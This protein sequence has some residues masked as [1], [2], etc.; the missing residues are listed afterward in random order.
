MTETD[1]QRQLHRTR[2]PY[3]F[4]VARTSILLFTVG[5]FEGR[6]NQD[7]FQFLPPYYIYAYDAVWDLATPSYFSCNPLLCPVY[8]LLKI[9]VCEESPGC[10][11]QNVF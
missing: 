9:A 11:Q 6:A 4:T 8:S 5:K 10:I 7:W 1:F 2:V 3:L